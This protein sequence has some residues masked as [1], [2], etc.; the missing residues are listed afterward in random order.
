MKLREVL[1]GKKNVWI[2]E[3]EPYGDGIIFV[4]GAYYNGISILPLDSGF[5]PIEMQIEAYE[6]KDST[7]LM[8]VR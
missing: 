2:K 4:G 3:Y 7:T 1:E 5:Y 6:W 8:I